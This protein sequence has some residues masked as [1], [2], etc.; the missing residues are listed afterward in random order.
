MS[1]KIAS[2]LAYG[3]VLLSLVVLFS[4]VYLGR[5]FPVYTT[6]L[7]AIRQ[8]ESI[9]MNWMMLGI[10]RLGD[11][12]LKVPVVFII[13]TL[14]WFRKYREAAKF[15]AVSCFGGAVLSIRLK[16]FLG[17][18]RPALWDSPIIETT[19]SYPSGHAL[20][21]VVL[22]GFLA[23]LLGRR[24]PHYRRWIYAGAI[25][26][27]LSIGFSRLYLGVHWP[28]DLLGGYMI[29]FLWTRVCIL[30]LEKKLPSLAQT[31]SM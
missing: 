17:K 20:G 14:L 31:I 11:P 27:S 1:R 18:T 25:A 2:L 23:Y 29:G 8:L 16:V 10:T 24:V 4:A 5:V 13:F 26:L 12:S 9:P 7:E 19:F 28:T 22:Y 6:I 30:F 15:F 21:S 3:F